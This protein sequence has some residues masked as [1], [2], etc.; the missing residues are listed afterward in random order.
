M[1]SVEIPGKLEADDLLK[2]FYKATQKVE[3]K[4]KHIG[5][6]SEVVIITGAKFFFRTSDYVG[7]ALISYYDGTSTKIDY[8]IVGGGSGIMNIHLGAGNDAV[9]DITKGLSDLVRNNKGNS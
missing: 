1:E 8:G 7:L 3:Y 9:N 4:N 2:V 6:D 5:P